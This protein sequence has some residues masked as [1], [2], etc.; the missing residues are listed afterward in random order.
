MSSILYKYFITWWQDCPPGIGSL[1]NFSNSNKQ[2]RIKKEKN[3]SMAKGK[4][5]D[6]GTLTYSPLNFY[7]KHVNLSN[8]PVSFFLHA[9]E[10]TPH[11]SEWNRKQESA[12][13]ELC[14][15]AE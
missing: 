4:D 6:Q 7:H 2:G 11:S 8:F 5:S 13:W 1:P 10:G 14:P 15:G 12:K 3:N 9:N